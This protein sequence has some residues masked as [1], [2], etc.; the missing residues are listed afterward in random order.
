MYYSINVKLGGAFTVLQ[1]QDNNDVKKDN[2][3]SPG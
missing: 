1:Y 2:P 3:P